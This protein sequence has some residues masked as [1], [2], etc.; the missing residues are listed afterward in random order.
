MASKTTRDQ[1]A[2]RWRIVPT[3]V[4]ATVAITTFQFLCA[5]GSMAQVKAPSKNHLKAAPAK[6]GPS[7]DPNIQ[8]FAIGTDGSVAQQLINLQ[9]D[10]ADAQAAADAVG[11]AVGPARHQGHQFRPRH[12]AVAGR[13]PAQAPGDAAALFRQ[14]ARRRTAPRRRRQLR[15]Q[16]GARRDRRR[17][18]ARL[19]PAQHHLRRRTRRPVGG[20]GLGQR[21]QGQQ[22]DPGGQPGADRRQPGDAEGAHPGPVRLLDHAGQGRGPEGPH[23]RR[24][25]A[26]FPRQP[27]RGSEQAILLVVC[28]AHPA[29][30]LVRRAGPPPRRHRPGRA[31]ARFAHLLAVRHAPLLR[32]LDAAA[33]STTASTTRARSASRSMRRRTA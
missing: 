28:A 25:A 11:K 26:R 3:L 24:L 32:P 20:R 6:A 2:Q 23:R 7:E 22:L 16:A 18:R 29:G 12:P 15:L 4:A 27:R 30:R 21:H 10:P 13:Q 31:Q 19:Q 9:I 5:A 1:R 14:V 8:P 33:A 17:G